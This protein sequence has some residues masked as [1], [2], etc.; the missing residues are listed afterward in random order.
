MVKIQCKSSRWQ[1]FF[2]ISIRPATLFKK[3]FSTGVLLQIYEIFKKTFFYRTPL[4]WWLLLAVNSVNQ[5]RHTLK[6]YPAEKR[7]EILEWYL[8]MNIHLR[9]S[10]HCW[11]YPILVTLHEKA[12]SS[13]PRVFRKKRYFWKFRKPKVVSYEI[14]EISKS[15]FFHRVPLVAASEK[16]KAVVLRCSVEK[17]FLEISQNLILVAAM[18]TMMLSVSWY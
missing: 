13:R 16:L 14:C 7:N 12:R 10:K 17:V 4:L 3:D 8:I 6:V 18:I 15:T 9:F 2:K 11:Q 1:I 5:W